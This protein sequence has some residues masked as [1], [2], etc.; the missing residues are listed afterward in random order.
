[1]LIRTQDRK[2]LVDI[3]GMIINVSLINTK[4]NV[5][6]ISNH[7]GNEF[8]KPLGV[9]STEEK[10]IKVLDMIQETYKDA[11][12]YHRGFVENKVFEMPTD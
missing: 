7:T 10:A 6:A 4:Y 3:T 12:Y 5:D 2:R 8:Y 1:M 9:Y 11:N